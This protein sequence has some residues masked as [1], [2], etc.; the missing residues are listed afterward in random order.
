MNSCTSRFRWARR[1]V[2]AAALCS[3]GAAWAQVGA[4]ITFGATTLGVNNTGELNFSGVGPS[5]PSPF[6]YGV[7]RAGVGDA[8][9]PGCFCE[10]WGVAL[11]SSGSSFAT[12]ANQNAGSGGFGSGNTFGFTTTTA[13]SNVNMADLPVSVRHAYG[14]S[15][16]ADV[17]QVQV[18]ITNKGTSALDNLLY[19][20][21]MDWDVPPTEFNEYVT[22]KGVVA[23]L[24][25]NGGN[26]LYASNNGFADSNPLSGAG[27]LGS[28]YT[29]ADRS[30]QISTVNTDFNKA[31]PADH[32][33]V[34]DFSFGQLAAG[35]SR[36]FNIYY[37]TAANEASA[38]SKIGGLGVNLYS[39]GQSSVGFGGSGGGPEVRHAAASVSGASVVADG[40][41]PAIHPTF[42]FAFGG[43]GGVEPGM[44]Q[45]V[46]ILPFVPAP[47]VFSFD[48]P[49]PRRWFD[50][51][52][53]TGFEISVLGGDM[54]SITAPTGFSDLKI[55]IGGVVVDG[56]FDG[57]ETYTFAAGVHTFKVTGMSVDLASAAPFPLFMDFAS[58]VTS[59]TWTADISAVPEPSTYLMFAGGLAALS[60]LRRR[61]KI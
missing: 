24:V 37:G 61:R 6:T 19:R 25:A 60:L 16:M 44:T 32:G 41:D 8:I 21:A 43:V 3:A 38:L 36:I 53:A 33:S 18:T 50:P 23:N 58:T 13:T 49:T 52:L 2:A 57:G 29:Y 22:H 1:L 10:G 56:D 9:S 31:G 11:S 47:G 17:F 5:G 20:R 35:S 40:D 30:T 14:P 39:L 34:F 51:P 42:I 4:V 27:D 28:Q 46:P 54:I 55:V 59:M 45:V 12:W 48:A 7:Y 26:V 15:L